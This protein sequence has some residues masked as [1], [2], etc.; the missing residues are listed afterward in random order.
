MSK[1]YPAVAYRLGFLQNHTLSKVHSD[2]IDEAANNMEQLSRA[3][4]EGGGGVQEET[5]VIDGDTDGVI[6]RVLAILE[7]GDGDDRR[8]GENI[9]D[10]MVDIREDELDDILRE[11]CPGLAQIVQ[12]RHSLSRIGTVCTAFPEYSHIPI[13]YHYHDLI[14]VVSMA[15]AFFVFRRSMHKQRRMI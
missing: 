12:N 15:D 5:V 11:V 9:D 2:D 7:D 14:M 4:G 1:D 3:A 10:E 13:L 8:G 6:E